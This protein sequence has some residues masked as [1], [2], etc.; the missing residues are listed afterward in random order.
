MLCVFFT[1]LAGCERLMSRARTLVLEDYP[2]E[3]RAFLE[4]EGIE[5]IQLGMP[6]NKVCRHHSLAMRLELTQSTGSSSSEC[7]TSFALP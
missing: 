2:E 4:G 3:N 1:Y 7:A 6:N 5:L